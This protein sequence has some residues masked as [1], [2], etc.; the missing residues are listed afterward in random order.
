MDVGRASNT[1][2]AQLEIAMLEFGARLL[3][4]GDEGDDVAELQLRLAG[5]LGG[6]PDGKFGSGTERQGKAFQR[7]WMKMPEPHGRADGAT[8]DAFGTF[9]QAHPVDFE[10]LA[11]DCKLC[12]GF[13][14]GLFKG[15]Y[16]A[17]APHI[18][19]NYRYEYPGVHRMLL[20]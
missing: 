1:L 13:G 18:E 2:S 11:C 19:M 5:F 15:E 7:E 14:R 9:A 12:D 20:W 8:L 17:G 3:A 4:V 10:L 16:A 6:V